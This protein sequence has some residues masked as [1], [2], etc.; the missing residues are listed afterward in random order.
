MFLARG[1]EEDIE[2][3]NHSDKPGILNITGTLY[4]PAGTV[5]IEVTGQDRAGSNII[6][7]EIDIEVKDG[8]ILTFDPNAGALVGRPDLVE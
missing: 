3:E 5:A 4:A 2:I 8:E 7:A 6:A 1:S